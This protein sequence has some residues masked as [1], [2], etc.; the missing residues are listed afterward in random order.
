[1]VR[2]LA[3]DFKSFVLFYVPREQYIQAEILSKLAS[4]KKSGK[5]HTVI[6]E[7]LISPNIE[8]E[9]VNFLDQSSNWTTPL[10]SISQHDILTTDVVE[11]KRVRREAAK[12]THVM[13]EIHQGI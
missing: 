11:A 10:I 9:E 13:R 3:K 6:Q 7:T 5:N 8:A 1:M 12:Y 4:T 2:S